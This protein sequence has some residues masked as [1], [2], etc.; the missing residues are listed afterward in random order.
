MNSVAGAMGRVL[1]M[2]AGTVVTQRSTRKKC[3][4]IHQRMPIFLSGYYYHVDA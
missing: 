4:D 1:Q 3:Y 2:S